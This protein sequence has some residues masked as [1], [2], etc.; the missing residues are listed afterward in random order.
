MAGTSA[1]DKQVEN[2]VAAKILVLVVKDRELLCI[3]DS[4]DRVNNAARK[5]PCKFASGQIVQNLAESK[6]TGPPHSDVK[7]G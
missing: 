7:N 4:S 2:L 5:K 1:H 3:D 6:Y